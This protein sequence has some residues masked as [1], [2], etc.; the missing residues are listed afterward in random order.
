[1]LATAQYAKNRMRV[2]AYQ[3]LCSVFGMC[4]GNISREVPLK[5]CEFDDDKL[6]CEGAVRMLLNTHL[7]VFHHH[8]PHWSPVDPYS[9]GRKYIDGIESRAHGAR[10]LGGHATETQPSPGMQLYILNFF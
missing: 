9:G 4:N 10:L 2:M 3:L 5:A 8:L 6:L 1:M 7:I